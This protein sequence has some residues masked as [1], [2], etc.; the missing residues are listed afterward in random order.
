MQ[1]Q[2]AFPMQITTPDLHWECKLASFA[3]P[4]QLSCAG[5]PV[6]TAGEGPT[7][8]KGRHRVERGSRTPPAAMRRLR[9]PARAT[10]GRA[11]PRFRRSRRNTARAIRAP[12]AD[13]RP[14]ASPKALS[15][16][17][18]T[19]CLTTP[20]TYRSHRASALA[21]ARQAVQIRKRV[22]GCNH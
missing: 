1:L 6:P 8:A 19:F 22:S 18:P 2:I 15:V 3:F 16:D 4:M 21:L 10:P 12:S 14:E 13:I 5:N 17:L 11:A 9:T 20:S 7:R